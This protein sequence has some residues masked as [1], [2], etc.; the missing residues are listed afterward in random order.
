MG[1]FISF[2]KTVRGYNHI[3]ADT[4]CEDFSASYQD[5]TGRF[6][7]AAISDGHGDSA[8]FRSSFG[9]KAAAEIAVEILKELGEAYFQESTSTALSMKEQLGYEK[10]RRML[11]RQATDRIISRWSSTVLR[12]LEENPPSEEE[13]SSSGRMEDSYRTGERLEHIYGATLIAALCL[14]EY[15]ILLQQ[16]D[17]RCDVFYEDGSVDQPIPWDSRCYENV[18]TSLCDPDS[19]DAVRTLVIDRRTVPVVAVY[20]GSDGVEDYY[21]NPEETQEGTHCFYRKLSVMLSEIETEGDIIEERLSPVLEQH[22]RDGNGDDV[23]V[24]GFY[25]RDELKRLLPTMST[26]AKKYED[27]D[28][29]RRQLT[30]YEQ[31]IGSMQRKHGILQRRAL[32][33]QAE[34]ADSEKAAQSCRDQIDR[35]SKE[36]AE[37]EEQKTAAFSAMQAQSEESGKAREYLEQQEN[38]EG[39]MTIIKFLGNGFNTGLHSLIEDACHTKAKEYESVSERASA[40]AAELETAEAEL[41]RLAAA[42]EAAQEHLRQAQAEFETYDAEYQ[43]LSTEK[44]KLLS[45]TNEDPS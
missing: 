22:T 20:L 8:C 11:L 1:K 5:D 38:S 12:D 10:G 27:D 19:E 13:Y 7:V 24:A 36:L 25:L 37:L 30:A 33:A 23:S 34:A 39:F 6:S 14:P 35:L 16:G 44:Q 43:R 42:E 2:H 15:I 4:P 41:G 31:K 45:C 18:T 26:A 32:E 29:L 28:I 21:P 3:K 17:G 9:S 40:K